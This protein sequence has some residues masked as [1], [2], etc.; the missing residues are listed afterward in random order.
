MDWCR[1]ECRSPAMASRRYSVRDLAQRAD[2]QR[3]PPRDGCRSLLTTARSRMVDRSVECLQRAANWRFSRQRGYLG[4]RSPPLF[5]AL[6]VAVWHRI[7]AG[8]S[9]LTKNDPRVLI[10]I[11][12]P[13]CARQHPFGRIYCGTRTAKVLRTK[14]APTRPGD[15]PL[16]LFSLGEGQKN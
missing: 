13:R 10:K 9:T 12:P 7:C 16:Q 5:L 15:S 1:R 3:L 6:I 8:A 2:R 14:E 11:D 4:Q